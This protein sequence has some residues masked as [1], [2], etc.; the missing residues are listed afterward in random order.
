M[1]SST[2]A[3]L[4]VVDDGRIYTQT[5]P[6]DIYLYLGLTYEGHVYYRTSY[7]FLLLGEGIGL[8]WLGMEWESGRAALHTLFTIYLLL[9]V[10]SKFDQN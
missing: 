6:T 3:Y 1:G 5:K 10:I 8:A 2:A 9:F 4:I 7:F